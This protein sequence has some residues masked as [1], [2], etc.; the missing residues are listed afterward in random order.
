MLDDVAKALGISEQKLFSELRDG[1]T[2][3]Q[4]AKAHD[5]SLDDVKRRPATRST[6]RLDAA[7]KDG[8]LTRSRP[9]R[10]SSASDDDRPPRRGRARSAGAG[11]SARR[12]G[13]PGRQGS[14]PALR[15]WQ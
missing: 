4:V 1:K 6:K 14:R 3:A 15:A 9:T 10:S 12:P 8:D 11:G 13:R 7:V 5:K 2:L